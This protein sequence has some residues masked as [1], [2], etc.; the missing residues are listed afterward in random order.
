MGKAVI[1]TLSIVIFIFFGSQELFSQV[2]IL[3][4][5]IS[6]N[7]SGI[8]LEN[9]L[10]EISDEADF[11]FSYDAS[12][13]PKKKVSMHVENEPVKNVLDQILPDNIDKQVSGNHLIL[14]KS[15]GS[16]EEVEITIEG[17]IT[18]AW[19]HNPLSDIV[20]YEVNTLVSDIS[21]ENGHYHLEIPIKQ[22]QIA[23][24]FS[25]NHFKDTVVIL[26]AE[27]QN[28]NVSLEPKNFVTPLDSIK[29]QPMKQ[30]V[31]IGSH[32]WVQGIVSEIMLERSVNTG[33][34]RERFFQVSIVPSIGSN[35]EMSGLVRNK[36]S[37]NI[38]S[39]YSYGVGAFEMGGFF[40]ITHTDV[41]GFQIAGLGNL[42]G[43]TTKGA[44][45]A[46]ILNHNNGSMY[47]F[48]I[49]GISNKVMDTLKGVQIAGIS[50]RLLGTMKG[51]QIAGI[52]N[53]AS[54]DVDGVQ[55]AGI[56]NISQ[57]NVKN[58][59]L[60]GLLNYGKQIEGM[61]FSGLI[62]IATGDVDGAQFAGLLNKAGELSNFQFAGLG[63]ISTD[64]VHGNQ[65]AGLF[66]I[67]K[68]TQGGQFGFFNF[69]DSTSGTPI[70]FFSFVTKGFRE[71][72]LSSREISPLNIAFKTG[73][74]SFY[75]IFTAGF[76]NW[77][78]GKQWMFG[79]GVGA[80]KILSRRWDYSFEY[81]A[82]WISEQRK[83][84][85]ELSLLNIFDLSF[86]YKS[87]NGFSVSFGPS[88]NF[89]ISE[90][91]DEESGEFLSDLAPYS[92]LE[93][94]IRGTRFQAWMGWKL[95]VHF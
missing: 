43:E 12:I 89:W 30:L 83:L 49:S 37:L 17:S 67:S 46:G 94:E 70:G 44:Q 21:D 13:L 33:F 65:Y 11:S 60:A 3:K 9:A 38:F 53:F 61:Q 24:K 52:N 5:K 8:Q 51:V 59:Q 76:G 81:T 73:V 93:D 50:N 88:F 82:N 84:Q 35:H 7:L 72:E 92:L 87:Q 6:L 80:R 27:N 68:Y 63:N 66:N 74:N 42:V 77:D 22:K 40:N 58:L 54:E 91:K 14:L 32:P 69:S 10:L 4:R 86:A 55:I 2:N 95:A 16:E 20:V 57:E 23:L 48:Q 85:E 26:E 31:P 39:G 28:F 36:L 29:S 71:I 90:W 18:K 1:N 62:N 79:Y 56:S 34:I 47:G 78:A 75:N 15:T 25:H 41:H 64:S 45:I 19:N